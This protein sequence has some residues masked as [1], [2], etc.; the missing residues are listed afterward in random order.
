MAFNNPYWGAGGAQTGSGTYD[1]FIPELW[2]Q[3]VDDYFQA[4]LV[5]KNLATDYSSLASGSG[6]LIHI[7]RFG[8]LSNSS[9][10]Q[11]NAISWSYDT[12]TGAEWTISLNQH[13][14]VGVLI[15]DIASVQ[16]SSDLLSGQARNMGYAM[17]KAVDGYIESIL[18]G[19]T[20]TIELS[21][22]T[23]ADDFVL[24]DIETVIKTV[25]EAD[26]DYLDGN[27]FMVL[28]P[29]LYASLFK[30]SDFAR[31][32]AVGMTAPSLTGFIGRL[33]GLPVYVST[34]VDSGTGGTTDEVFGY[35]FHR[36]GVGFASQLGVR[37]QS[38]Y[39]I[40][41]LGDKVVADSIYGCSLLQGS[42]ANQKKVWAIKNQS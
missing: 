38:D 17:A 18:S 9:K 6:D 39:S 14:Y 41:H 30:S 5:F 34:Q 28:K 27:T 15:E 8:A 3:G 12:D 26:I 13:E 33:A 1:K 24:A 2:A 4:N 16:S 32:D 25:A 31:A 36:S 22:A 20:N 21:S 10:E 29:S 23:S 35:V 7:P 19:T 11:G 42:G 37:M 40:D